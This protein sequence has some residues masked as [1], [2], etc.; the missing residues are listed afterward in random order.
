MNVGHVTTNPDAIENKLHFSHL[1]GYVS[2]Y[3]LTDE[4]CEELWQDLLTGLVK[5]KN[6]HEPVIVDQCG[7]H[8]FL[9]NPSGS[10]DLC[11]RWK[12]YRIV[13]PISFA[14]LT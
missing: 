11:I 10:F 1:F 6:S 7:E 3:H 12:S 9:C 13:E 4:M 5:A 2:A 14:R 8:F